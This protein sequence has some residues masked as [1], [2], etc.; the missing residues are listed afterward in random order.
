MFVSRREFLRAGALVA[1]ASGIPLHAALS[2]NGQQRGTPQSKPAPAVGQLPGEVY[3]DP[4]FYYTKATFAAYVNTRF[5][6]QTKTLRW[7]PLTLI[8]VKTVGPVPDKETPGKECFSLI[9]RSGTR[10][11]QNTY[12]LTHDVLGTFNL[13]LV[14]VG[15]YYKGQTYEAVINRLN[16]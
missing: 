7:I 13:F 15:R 4:L 12:K 1:L 11:K 5:Q 8:E 6:F 2:V 3:S 9:F 10:F 14:P 16:P